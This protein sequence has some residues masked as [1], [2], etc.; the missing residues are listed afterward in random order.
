MFLHMT[1]VSFFDQSLPPCN[2]SFLGLP[3][4]SVSYP[5]NV[6]ALLV[7]IAGQ[8]LPRNVYPSL[9]LLRIEMCWLVVTGNLL[10]WATV[11][12]IFSGIS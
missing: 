1:S 11:S 4:M 3:A 9:C 6:G 7:D 2:F 5:V 8:F 10:T 12:L